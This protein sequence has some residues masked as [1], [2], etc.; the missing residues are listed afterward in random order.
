[1]GSVEKNHG[2]TEDTEKV[3]IPNLN[4]QGFQSFVI[5]FFFV[6]SVPLWLK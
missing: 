5:T 2:E 1:M 4:V 3:M 6:S